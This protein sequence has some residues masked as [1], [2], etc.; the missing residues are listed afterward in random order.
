MD[1][2]VAVDENALAGCASDYDVEPDSPVASNTVDEPFSA[3][4]EVKLREQTKQSSVDWSVAVDENANMVKCSTP[5]GD[6]ITISSDSED[7]L[8]YTSDAADE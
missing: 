4:D 6:V 5:V 1:C 3:N 2:S 8:L 7:C